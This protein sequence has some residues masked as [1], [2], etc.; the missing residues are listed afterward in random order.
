MRQSKLKFKNHSGDPEKII[1]IVDI[2]LSNEYLYKIV[3]QNVGDDFVD[4]ELCGD[5]WI[6]DVGNGYPLLSE[7]YNKSLKL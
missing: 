1:A 5:Y 2:Q 6:E 4:G 7:L 3:C